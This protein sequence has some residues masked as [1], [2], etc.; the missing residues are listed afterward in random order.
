MKKRAQQPDAYTFTTLFRGFSLNAHYPL[1]VS[2]ALS[3]YH[4]MFAENS[5][6]KPNTIHTNAVL[7]VCAMAGDMDGLLGVAAKLPTR[8][9]GAPNNLT[10][11]TILNG[12]RNSAWDDT[13]AEAVSPA[14]NERRSRAVM[15]G[16]RLWEEIRDRWAKGDLYID[17]ELVCA[18]GRL[19]LISNEEQ[20]CDDILSLLEQTMGLARQIPRLGDPA[21]K[22]AS[23]DPEAIS[24]SEE[25]IAENVELQTLLPPLDP[26]TDTEASDL[27]DPT[28]SAFAPLSKGPPASQSP[29]RPGCNSLSLVID[30]CIRLHLVRAA[31]NYWGLL[32]SPEG[33]YNIIPD[34]ENFHMYLRLLRIQRASKMAVEL[35]EEMRR[36]DLGASV[37]LKTKTFRIA[38]SCC[39][40]DKK[41]RHVLENA[42]KLVR[43]MIDALEHPD[44]RALGMYL[45]LAMSQTP[46]DWRTIMGV[47]R[48]TELGV[49]NLRSLLAYDPRGASKQSEEDVQELV[50]RLIGAFDTV[51]DLG[52]EDMSREEKARCREQRH[53]LASYVTRKANRVQQNRK[54]DI[55]R[56]QE[57][58]RT[59]G[60]FEDEAEISNV[61][62]QHYEDDLADEEV[63]AAARKELEQWPQ[64]TKGELKLLGLTP[65]Q[66][67]QSPRQLGQSPRQLGQSPRQ[68]G[69]SPRQLGQ[70]SNWKS[71]L[72]HEK[73]GERRAREKIARSRREDTGL[74]SDGE[75]EW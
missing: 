32:T 10:F 66:L 4:S 59:H 40:R 53:T 71:N 68:L 39:V 24:S 30:A 72:R 17:E 7:K 74:R 37:Q 54:E 60:N 31:Q 41:N 2:R 22:V 55:E 15:Q 26:A 65:R 16:R 63:D 69:Q 19:L 27:S 56:R 47:I 14:K 20:D 75:G 64:G 18:M 62:N 67:G 1:S 38:M 42:G 9:P 33:T 57:E 49:R 50:Q 25:A 58:F 51:L 36:G 28:T 34:A 35:V 52:N 21:R 3:I 48:G 6:V 61:R 70:T 45:D 8:G 73:R 23:R 11:T 46:R 44:A 29:I 12:I 43:M 5:P 13:K